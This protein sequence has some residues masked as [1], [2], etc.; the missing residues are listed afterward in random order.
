M[1]ESLTSDIGMIFNNE[2]FSDIK[3]VFQNEE[4]KTI[5]AHKCI[6]YICCPFFRAMVSTRVHSLILIQSFSLIVE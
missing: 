6:L 4:G 1:N 2:K 3:F 5:L